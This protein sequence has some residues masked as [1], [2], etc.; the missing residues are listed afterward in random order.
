[1]IYIDTIAAC[2]RCSAEAGSACTVKE[3]RAIIKQLGW[4]RRKNKENDIVED[5]CPACVQKE[6]EK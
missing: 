1:M 6:K 2:D 4:K 3:T 5:V